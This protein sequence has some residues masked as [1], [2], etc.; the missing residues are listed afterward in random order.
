MGGPTIM[1]WRPILCHSHLPPTLCL[2]TVTLGT[3]LC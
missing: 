3:L 1:P 2:W